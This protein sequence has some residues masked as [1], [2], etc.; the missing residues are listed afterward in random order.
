MVKHTKPGEMVVDWWPEG[1]EEKFD[2]VLPIEPLRKAI[3]SLPGGRCLEIGCGNG[4]W[5]NKLL[6]PKFDEV[7][8]IDRIEKPEGL[9]AKYIKTDGY[10]LPFEDKSFDVVYSFGVFCHF[11]LED[12][13]SYLK[14]IKRV[15]RGKALIGFANW[16]RHPD[17]V[18]S[19]DYANGWHYNDL[20]ITK[21]MCKDFKFIDFDSNYRDTLAILW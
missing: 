5:T 6:V 3:N 20:E 11:Y 14:E 10:S 18:N 8:C 2:S 7:V 12:Q 9:K 19:E 21:E 4:Y 15:L 16:K 1:Y 17:L 13:V